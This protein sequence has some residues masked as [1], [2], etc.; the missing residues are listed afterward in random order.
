MDIEYEARKEARR[1]ERELRDEHMRME[2]IRAGR[3]A[4][5]EQREREFLEVME[6][7]RVGSG[8]VFSH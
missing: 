1:M 2:Y 8:L 5:A 4:M 6:A 3:R 7:C